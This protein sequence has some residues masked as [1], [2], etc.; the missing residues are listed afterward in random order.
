MSNRGK[1]AAIMPAMLLHEGS[2]RGRYRV[3]D[4]EGRVTDEHSSHVQC[5]FPDDGEFCY[6]QRNRF[7]WDD[8]REFE[9]EFG[10]RLEGDRILWD[11]DRFSGFGWATQDNVVLLTLERK[12]EPGCHFTEVIVLS[13]DHSHRAR[14]WHW[15]RDGELYQRTL[16][17]ERRVSK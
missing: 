7:S 1:L 14:T 10:G 13:P 6:V 17:D 9:S 2:W 11:T 5:E 3:V 12:D 15:F 4:L 8:G 16:C